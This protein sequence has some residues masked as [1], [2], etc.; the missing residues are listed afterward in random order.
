M[1]FLTTDEVA[2]RYRTAASTVRY[3]RQIGKGPRAIKI[4]RRV[5]YPEAD[6]LRYE[7]SLAEGQDDLGLIS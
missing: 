2:V 1:R 5:L 3:W 7:R 4:G 6:L